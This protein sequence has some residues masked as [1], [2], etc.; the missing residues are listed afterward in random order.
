MWKR[1]MIGAATVCA[2][3]CALVVSTHA[4]S[5]NATLVMRSGEKVTGQLV[6]MGGAGFTVRVSG[7]ERQIPTNDVAVIDFAGGGDVSEA[8][9]NRINSGGQTVTLRNRSEERRVGKERRARW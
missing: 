5:A 2:A 8:E 6:D 3:V 4:Q 1:T 7:Q 9:L